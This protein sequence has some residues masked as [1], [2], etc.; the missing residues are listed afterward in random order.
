MSKGSIDQ[1][2]E[3]QIP[4][5]IRMVTERYE[6]A[7]SLFDTVFRQMAGMSSQPP[8]AMS[9]EEEVMLGI[10][11]DMDSD[12]GYYVKP[13][14]PAALGGRMETRGAG[15]AKDAVERLEL[16]SEGLLIR[17]AVSPQRGGQEVC[18]T[19]DE[20][21]LTGMEGARSTLTFHTD[22]P[23]LVSLMR[24]GS[25]TTA[26]TFRAHCRALCMYETPYMPFQVGIHCLVVDNRL[27]T[28]GVLRLDYIVEIRGA[29][30]E[31]C[32]MDMTLL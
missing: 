30:A 28:D 5:R 14:D 25:V 11:A 7:A 3:Q 27:L 23:G 17:K 19:Y 21:E 31:R 4:V 26:M 2:P 9:P 22:D 10:L 13:A 20:S 29:R 12:S 32:R 15:K 1:T 24:S 8:V 18:V 16:Y 6:V